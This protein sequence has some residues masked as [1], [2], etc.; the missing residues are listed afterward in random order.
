MRRLQVLEQMRRVD[1]SVVMSATVMM[2]SY[3]PLPEPPKVVSRAAKV[4]TT[5]K[6]RTPARLYAYE[7]HL[8]RLA[9]DLENMAA[10]LGQ[11]I[12]EAHAV[13]G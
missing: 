3:R 4:A 7:T 6:A 8:E 10:A 11:F 1:R 5:L 13:V 2:G 9:Q 12:Q